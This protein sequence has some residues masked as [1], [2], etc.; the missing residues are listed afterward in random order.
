MKP[1]TV[2][3]TQSILK[4]ITKPVGRTG[5]GNL[6]TYSYIKLGDEDSRHFHSCYNFEGSRDLTIYCAFNTVAINMSFKEC[7]FLA[8]VFIWAAVTLTNVSTSV[9]NRPKRS[10][11]VDP[12][13]AVVEQLARQVTSLSTQLTQQ[14][15]SFN[16]HL[17]AVNTEVT[18]LKSKTG[19]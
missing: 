14:G 2:N 19:E 9:A 1:V 15:N 16:V 17:N 11:D 13:K 4:N 6:N 10:D 7:P 18:A 8:V 5:F 12:L 3:P